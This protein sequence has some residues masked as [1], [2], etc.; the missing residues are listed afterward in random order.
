M[1]RYLLRR[2][3]SLCVAF[4]L[5]S[6]FVFVLTRVLPG[7]VAR[8]LAGRDAGSAQ[9]AAI[10]AE[11]GLDMPLPVQYLTWLRGFVAGDWGQ[12]FSAPRQPVRDLALQRLS[13]S[14]YLALL[15]VLIAVPLSVVLGVLAALNENGPLD[16]LISTTTLTVV[17]LPEFVTA[18]VLING[19][20]LGGRAWAQAQGWTWWFPASSAIPPNSNFFSALPSLWL[21]ALCAT[22][23]LLAYLVRLTRAGMIE[24]LKRDYVTQAILK[25]LPYRTV[26]FKHVLRNALIPTVTAIASSTGWLLSGLVVIEYT[27]SYPGLGRLLLF[28]IDN[29]DLNLLQAVVMLTVVTILTANMLADVAYAL[30]NPRIRLGS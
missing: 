15:T 3:L 2:G 13:N 19:V 5:T 20:A 26:I 9:L 10:R 24:E 23:V 18:L 22:L 1:S 28:S 12:T 14:G 8:A 30:L 29:R 27:F 6:L 7:D 16:T 21:P 4:I 11:L 17:S 25:G